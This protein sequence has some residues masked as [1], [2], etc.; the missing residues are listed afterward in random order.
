MD[1]FNKKKLVELQIV[2]EGLR[3]QKQEL[4]EELKYKDT[5]I[6]RLLED[7]SNLI[8]WIEKILEQAQIYEGKNILNK[9]TIPIIKF[10][11]EKIDGL[12]RPYIQKDITLPE[13]HFSVSTVNDMYT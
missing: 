3:S 7:N 2:N 5:E 6:S 10:E 9:I 11:K 8:E 4:K 12:G 13:I 1:L